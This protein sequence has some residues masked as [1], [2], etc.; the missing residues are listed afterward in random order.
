WIDTRALDIEGPP[1][2]FFREQAGVVLTE[3]RL[4]GH[5]YEGFVRVVFAT[6]RPILAEAFSAMG[7][8]LETRAL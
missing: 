8:A 1:A 4:L 6:P 3:G 5:G 2:A 7:E